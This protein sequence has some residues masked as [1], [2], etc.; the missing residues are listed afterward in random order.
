MV[1]LEGSA[2]NGNALANGANGTLLNGHSGDKHD[3]QQKDNVV[4]A[5]KG[6]L[7]A[8]ILVL[9]SPRLAQALSAC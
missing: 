1:E 8:L 3:G 2:M 7:E 5:S 9:T 6:L 4:V